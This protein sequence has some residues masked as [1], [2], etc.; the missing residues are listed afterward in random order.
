LYPGT[1]A[2]TTPDKPAVIMGQSGE[3]VSYQT[4]DDR[5]ARLSQVLFARGLR[6]GDKIALLAENHPRFYEVYWAALRSG[7]YLTPVNRYLAAEEAAYLV[8]DSGSKACITTAQMAPTAV[9]MLHLI[10]N[11]PIRLMMDGNEVGF[12]SY[13]CCAECVFGCALGRST[14]GRSNALL[15]GDDGPTQGS[16]AAVERLAD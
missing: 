16:G 11:C 3:V 2:A 4:L 7:L 10:P 14:A 8:T 12:E 15:V 6:P 5:S 13:Q 9:P 1:F